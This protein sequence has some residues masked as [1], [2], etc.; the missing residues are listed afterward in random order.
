MHHYACHFGPPTTRKPL[1]RLVRFELTSSAWKAEILPL[2]YR[3][4]IMVFTNSMK[5][6]RFPFTSSLL[7]YDPQT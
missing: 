5:R 2:N 3:R 7:T 1:E 6:G 4:F